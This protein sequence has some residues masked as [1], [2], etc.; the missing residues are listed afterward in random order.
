MCNN[1][2]HQAVKSRSKISVINLRKAIIVLFGNLHHVEQ[3]SYQEFVPQRILDL[4]IQLPYIL[5]KK[6]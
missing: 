6:T 1:S 3:I 2:N 4:L 5:K